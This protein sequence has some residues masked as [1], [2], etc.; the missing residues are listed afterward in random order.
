[1]YTAQT[2]RISRA[3]HH[4][5]RG[6]RVQSELFQS[7]KLLRAIIRLWFLTMIPESHTNDVDSISIHFC[8]M[9]PDTTVRR[10]NKAD[11]GNLKVLKL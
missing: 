5:T 4:R 10:P 3:P 11:R 8:V 7:A 2:R 9:A 6:M 1:M